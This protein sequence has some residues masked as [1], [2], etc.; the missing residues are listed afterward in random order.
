MH[1]VL[2][3]WKRLQCALDTISTWNLHN[4][5]VPWRRWYALDGGYDRH[6]PR[7]IGQYGF[8][9]LTVQTENVGI[10][11]MYDA[12]CSGLMARTDPNDLLFV[13]EEDW[14]CVRTLPMDTITA[15]MDRPGP[16]AVRLFGRCKDRTGRLRVRDVRPGIPGAP[17]TEW[18]PEIIGSEQCLVGQSFWC[19][20]PTITTLELA[21]QFAHEAAKEPI[22]IE[23]SCQAGLNV[24]WLAEPCFYHMSG[25]GRLALGGKR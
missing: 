18:R 22:S 7:M 11:G 24:A 6:M 16:W 8:Q 19:H 9:P 10:A 1:L 4:R 15:V 14:E 20:P 13:L 21:Y 25:P 5:P 12:I 2:L 17:T 23:R 3:A